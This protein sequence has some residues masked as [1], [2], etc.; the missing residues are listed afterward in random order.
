[1]KTNFSDLIRTELYKQT[2]G[3]SEKKKVQKSI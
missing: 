3:E 2:K 1:M